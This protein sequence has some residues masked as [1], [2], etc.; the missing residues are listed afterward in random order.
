MSNLL[1]P[2]PAANAE[3]IEP[4]EFALSN[5]EIERTANVVKSMAHPLRLKLLC[6]LSEGEK[7]V[8]ELTDILSNTSQSNVSQH[9]SHL[10]ERGILENRKVGNQVR[11]RIRD[12]RIIDLVNNMRDIYCVS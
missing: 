11:Y 2:A 5:Q 9:L 4:H 12:D 3:V 6:L 1:S 8:Q 7:P 10:L